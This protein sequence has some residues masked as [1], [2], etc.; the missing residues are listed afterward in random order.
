MH[1][2]IFE[3]RWRRKALSH[4]A[5]HKTMGSY[6]SLPLLSQPEKHIDQKFIIDQ[7]NLYSKNIFDILGSGPQQFTHIPWHEDFRLKAQDPKADYI[8]DATSFY[9]DIPIITGT[10]AQL[11]KD[12]KIPW[13]L[14]R[15]QHLVILG[16]AYEITQD[17]L[18]AQTFAD[19]I[20]NWIDKNSYMIGANWVGPMEVGIRAI[21]WIWAHSQFKN[22]PSIAPELWQTMTASL[23]DHMHYLENNWEIYDGKTSNHYLS[24]LIGYFYLCW[25][26]YDTLGIIK[27]RDWCYQEILKECDKQIFDEGTSYESSTAYH[28]LVTEIFDHFAM[29][30]KHFNM[31]LPDAFTQKLQRM[32]EF[33]DACMINEHDSI[34][35]GDD[36]SGHLLISS[37]DPSSSFTSFST[38]REGENEQCPSRNNITTEISQALI[39]VI[40]VKQDTQPIKEKYF[41]PS[42]REAGLSRVLE[43]TNGNIKH[44]TKFG[45]SIIK[46]PTW[47]ISLRHHAYQNKQPSGH[48]HNDALSVTIAAYGIP[49]VID[50]G[51][52]VYTPST[53]WRNYFRS[54]NVHN[55]FFIPDHEPIPFDDRLFALNI[56]ENKE[57]IAD[58]QNTLLAQHNLYN[59]FGLQ[60]HRT[61][62]VENNITTITDWWSA[63]QPIDHQTSCCNFT[64]HPA[65]TAKKDN[66]VWHFYYNDKRIA[67]MHSNL[68]FVLHDT[69]VSLHYGSKV[70]SSCLRA[71]APLKL[72]K[73]IETIF[74]LNKPSSKN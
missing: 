3:L 25:V 66:N 22:S 31:I 69:W 19:H 74:E 7:A 56:P 16:Y 32:H 36:D 62:H 67:S 61:V 4:T 55:T 37:R 42:L 73:K 63:D 54:V 60:A 18:Y 41:P 17:E 57:V 14:S 33:I 52:Y 9:K 38:L 23:Y 30:C 24:D 72:D 6:H 47:H 15:C 34:K 68:E 46:T 50:P 48:I 2:K 44:Y 29:L 40:T 53:Y 49:I 8:F 20:T 35:I 10:D 26:F 45:L 64:L 21:N 65:I 43:G 59:R 58:T 12:I 28:G 13:E 71:Q 11:L 5:H 1:N 70:A 39:K 27:K 51:S